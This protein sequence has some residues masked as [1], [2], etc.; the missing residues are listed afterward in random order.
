MIQYNADMESVINH[1]VELAVKYEHEY[2]MLE[3]VLLSLVSQKTFRALLTDFG[4]DVEG[5]EKDL[6]EYLLTIPK[7]SHR[8]NYQPKRTNSLERIFNRALTQVLFSG[9]N[10]VLPIDLFLS[11][12]LEEKSHA[13]YFIQKYDIDRKELVSFFNQNYSDASSTM[14]NNKADLV[15]DEHCTNL[16]KLAEDEKID[17]VIGRDSELQE[18]I[19]VLARKNKSNVLLVGDPGVG[20]TAIV[21]GLALE[22]TQGNVPE[23]LK[24]HVVYNLDVGSM[25]AGSKYRGDFEEKLKDTIK[26]LQAK[27][28]CILFIDEAHQMHGA[29]SGG[30][31][32]G[33]D[34]ANMLKPALAKGGLKVI[35]STT[36]EEYTLSFEKDRALMRRFYRLT[37]DEPTA[38]VT[39]QILTRLK[40][41][42]EKFHGGKIHLKAV[43]AAVDYSVRYITDKKLPDKAIDLIDM[44]CAKAKIQ[45]TNFVIKRQ[46]ILEVVSKTA[47]IPL[48]NLTNESEAVT[49]NLEDN[50]KQKL[51]GQDEAIGQVLEKIYIAKAGLKTI[52][53]PIGNFL[54]LGPTGVGKTELAKLLSENLQMKL[55]RY[56]M[57]EYQERHAVAKLIGAPPGYVGYEDGNLGGG[58]LVSDIEKNPHSV[59]LFD[60]IEKAHPD[61]SNVL[62]QL[63]DEGTVTSSNGKKVSAR[64]TIVI[65]TSNLGATESEK[66]TI[67][68]GD[69]TRHGEDDKAVKE[70]FRPEFR[71][72]LDG[73][74]KFKSLD[75]MYVKR[76]VNKFIA[77][78]NEMLAQ[79][80][81][82]LRCTERCVDALATK[83]YDK[84][85]GARPLARTIDSEI[86]VPLSKKI[87]FEKIPTDCVIEVDFSD[88]F[89]FNVILNSTDKEVNLGSEILVKS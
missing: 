81:I 80:N 85:M 3:H 69:L 38:E 68:F 53:K 15:L 88:K 44:A 21:E 31:G 22:I 64:N 63:M 25:L 35:A 28:N 45:D 29:G 50:I 10:H 72:R 40:P 58:L 87:L 19:Q 56:D 73:V 55:I 27:G 62:L 34:L 52:N 4:T 8:K 36:W 77:D 17:P 30:G 26:A 76:I 89:L 20:K 57:S 78:L 71:N 7:H 42:Y 9:R 59:V 49:I 13:S 2:V 1:A 82:K 33:V 75:V 61:V 18:I 60:E 86:K 51:Y 32:G 84:K 14:S 70:F 11:I 24:N 5:L 65:L 6:A 37:V 47:K 66:N 83:G 46:H 79:K 39:K 48:E 41:I 54:F 74:I 43:T 67:G 16:N 23:H 12:S